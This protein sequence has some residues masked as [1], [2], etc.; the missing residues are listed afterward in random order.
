MK[1]QDPKYTIVVPVFNEVQSVAE[2]YH[3]VNDNMK[4]LDVPFE[5]LFVDDGSTDGTLEQL[6]ALVHKDERISVIVLRKNF[7]KSL[8]LRE[9][10]SHARG[11][12]IITIDGDLQDEPGE[13]P[14]LIDKIKEGWDLVTGWKRERKDPLEKKLPSKFFNFLT[15]LFSGLKLHDY[16]CGFKIYTRKIAESIPM[17]GELHRFIPVLAHWQGFK[18]TEIP[19]KHNPRKFGKSKFGLNRY[20]RGFFDF[21]SVFFLTRYLYRPMHFFGKIGIFLCS[22]G[23]LICAYLSAIWF[24]GESIGNRPLL[25]FG[26]LL[27]IIGIQFFSTGLVAELMTLKSAE[28]QK[29]SIDPVQKVIR[30]NKELTTIGLVGVYA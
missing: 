7:G 15:S 12:Y 29:F 11:E 8:A 14:V 24:S 10:F 27:L 28:N 16:N 23:F 26:V 1:K 20:I 4:K 9:G 3:Q 6:S 22:I 17:Y 18:V 2:L 30:K 25:L 5:I 19:V 13:L 21:L